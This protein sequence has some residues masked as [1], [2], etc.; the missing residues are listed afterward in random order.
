ME[1]IRVEDKLPEKNGHYWV[2]PYIN[3]IG[4]EMVGKADFY[5]GK[6]GPSYPTNQ[7]YIF[8]MPIKKPDPPNQRTLRI[9]E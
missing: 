9:S 2:Y 8:W 4:Q 5:D 1:W 6:F 3:L 7:N